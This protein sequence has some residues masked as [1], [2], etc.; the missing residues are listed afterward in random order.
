MT[1]PVPVSY[2]SPMP[3][4]LTKVKARPLQKWS[5]DLGIASVPLGTF[6][7]ISSLVEV[8]FWMMAT[9]LATS[10][11]SFSS[12]SGLHVLLNDIL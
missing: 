11:L 2:E 6:S 8:S 12:S 3:A 7:S 10:G 1:K 5:S 9:A 4:F